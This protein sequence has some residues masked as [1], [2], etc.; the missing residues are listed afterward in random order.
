MNPMLLPVSSSTLGLRYAEEPITP[1]TPHTPP[2][3]LHLPRDGSSQDDMETHRKRVDLTKVGTFLKTVTGV[4]PSRAA[5]WLAPRTPYPRR[6]THHATW[7]GTV[8]R[9]VEGQLT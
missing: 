8:W 3:S 1:H 2:S 5:S 9:L 7:A 4:S 6:W